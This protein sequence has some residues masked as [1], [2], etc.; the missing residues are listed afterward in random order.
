MHYVFNNATPPNVSNLFTYSSKIH[1]HN[2]Q[3]SVAGNFY[4][5]HSRMDHK[6]NSFSRSGAKIW[7]SIPN[8]DHALPEYIFKNTLQSLLLDIL[9]HEDTYVDLRTLINI[10]SKYK[11]NFSLISFKHCFMLPILNVCTHCLVNSI[12]VDVPVS[13]FFIV[14]LEVVPVI[15]FLFLPAQLAR[16]FW[17]QGSM[18][19]IC[20]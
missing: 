7:N 20:I 17:G 11:I 1:L 6:K 10:F 8:S 12:H 16:L 5:K 3:F 19:M 18:V 4:L 9:I 2:I 15:S 13:V 14:I